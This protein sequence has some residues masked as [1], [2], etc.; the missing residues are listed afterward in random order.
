VGLP[1]KEAPSSS[2]MRS[3]ERW[4]G[5]CAAGRAAALEDLDEAHVAAAAR[6]RAGGSEGASASAAGAGLLGADRVRTLARLAA[7]AVLAKKAVVAE[8][9]EAAWDA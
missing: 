1:C 6:T 2:V 3:P 9:M 7:R 8:A 4:P 5:W